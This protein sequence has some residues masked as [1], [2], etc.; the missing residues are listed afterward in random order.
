MVV[1]EWGGRINC[2]ATKGD[3]DFGIGRSGSCGSQ[4]GVVQ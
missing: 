1:R 4:G 2:R 3:P